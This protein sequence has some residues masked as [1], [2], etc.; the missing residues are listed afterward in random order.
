MK[1]FLISH[2]ADID[3][4]TPVILSELAFN[5]FNYELLEATDVDTYMNEKLKSNF[6]DSFDKV[7]MTDLCVGSDVAELINNSSLKDKFI[8]FDHHYTNLELN[9][10]D[11]INVV[12]E[13]NGIKECGTTLY[14]R[15]LLD[16]YPNQH[17][18]KNSVAYMVSLVRLNDTWLWKE[19]GIE[20]ARYLTILLSYYGVDYYINNYV[21]FLKKNKEFY[22]TKTENILIETD[23]RRISEYINEKKDQVIF[24]TINGKKAGI[25]F[26]ELYRSELGNELALYYADKVDFIIIINMSRSISYRGI[27]EENSL[28]EFATMYG[29]KGHKKAAGSPLPDGLK[30]NIIEFIYGGN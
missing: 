24:K 23:N 21:D 5:D 17:L 9:L 8:I 12:D 28:G 30:E 22:F 20:E 1:V 6:F 13:E 2:I 27:K 18:V 19:L 7:Y 16:N 29:G 3:G 15:Y 25:V 10:Y 4:L 11:F 26:A 14:Y